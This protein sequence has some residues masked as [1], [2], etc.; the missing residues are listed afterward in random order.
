MILPAAFTVWD[1]VALAVQVIHLAAFRS[2]FTIR[3]EGPDRQQNVSVR[4][5]A[6]FQGQRESILGGS[7]SLPLTQ[8]RPVGRSG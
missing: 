5:A 2:P 6:L 4:V 8:R 7:V 3:T 1:T